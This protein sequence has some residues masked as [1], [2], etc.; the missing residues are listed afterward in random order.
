MIRLAGAPRPPTQSRS[1]VFFSGQLGTGGAERQMTRIACGYQKRAR[2]GGAAPQV[3]V[4]HANPATGADFFCPTLAVASVETRVLTEEPEYD[5]QTLDGLSDD[6]KAILS[7]MAPDLRKHTGQLISM[8]RAHDTDVAYLWQDG[9]I[10]QSAI[11]AVIAG[12]PRIVTSFRGLP[13]N[14]RP[15]F[16]RDE[17]PVLYSA[18][19]RLPHVTFTANSQKTATAY[20]DWLSLPK[21]SVGVIPNATPPVLADGDATDE[22][23]WNRIEMASRDCTRTVLGVFRFDENKRPLRW[24]EAAER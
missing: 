1:V 15:H 6:L 18:L 13:P 22:T 9:G 23:L 16:F 5:I 3:W 21:G 7:L 2:A 19:A 14:L 4:K 24:I 12:V 20:E 8:F 17:L 11:A 10:V